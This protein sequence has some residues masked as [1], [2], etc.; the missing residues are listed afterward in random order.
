MII[1]FFNT[2]DLIGCGTSLIQLDLCTGVHGG[3]SRY[4]E[5]C[6]GAQ[7]GVWKGW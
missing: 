4:V 2:N 3:A 6:R 7:I 5:A 1:S